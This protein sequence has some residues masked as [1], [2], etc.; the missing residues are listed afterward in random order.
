VTTTEKARARPVDPEVGQVGAEAAGLDGV[1]GAQDGLEPL[2]QE[3]AARAL[4]D[5]DE[6]AL[7]E[8]LAGDAPPARAQ[9]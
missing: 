6:Q 5:G 8:E 3:D 9:R 1:H 2:G 7:R 4:G